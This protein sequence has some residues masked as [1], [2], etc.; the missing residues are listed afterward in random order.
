MDAVQTSFDCSNLEKLMGETCKNALMANFDR[1]L[2]LELHEAK[3]TNG[4]GKRL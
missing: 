4:T 2:K 3:L 1:K